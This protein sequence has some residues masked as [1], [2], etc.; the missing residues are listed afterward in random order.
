MKKV[1]LIINLL[2]IGFLCA[3][4]PSGALAT[5]KFTGGSF[6]NEANPGVGDLVPQGSGWL[7]RNDRDGNMNSALRNRQEEF[8]GLV[9]NQAT[10]T[11]SFSFWYLF[12]NPIVGNNEEGILQMFDPQ[13]EGVRVTKRA[14]NEFAVRV[15]TT[16]ADQTIVFT[17]PALSQPAWAHV[18][19]N[20]ARRTSNFAV[21]VLVNGNIAQAQGSNVVNSTGS[22]L[23]AGAPFILSPIVS[24]FGLRSATD[25]I[26][27]YN[28]ELALGDAINLSNEP[29]LARQSRVYV[30]VD[31]TGNQFGTSWTD[32]VT[33]LQ[34]AIA[35]ADDNAEI[36][37]AD[38]TYTSTTTNRTIPVMTIDK[39]VSILGGFNGSET[40]V[41]QR[42]PEAN[43]TIITGD[44]NDNDSV[45]VADNATRS[46]NIN[47]LLDVQVNGV[48]VDGITLSGAMGAD[49]LSSLNGSGAILIRNDLTD[50]TISNCIIEGNVARFR[51]SVVLYE[52]INTGVSTFT[53][54]RCIVR[55]NLTAQGGIT[56]GARAGSI[57]D[58]TIT[59][60]VIASN[61]S[62]DL[63]GPSQPNYASAIQARVMELGGV[64]NFVMINCTIAGNEDLNTQSFRSIYFDQPEANNNNMSIEIYNNVFNG[65]TDA[66]GFTITPIGVNQNNNRTYLYDFDSNVTDVAFTAI[67]DADEVNT[68]FASD[69]SF[70]DAINGD[71]RPVSGSILIDSG[72]SSLSN[73]SMDLSG[74]N[75][76]VGNSI[77]IGAYEFGS[78]AGLDNSKLSKI[79]VYPNPAVDMIYVDCG[80]LA[81]AK[82][83]LFNLHG[84][85]VKRST[86][87]KIEVAGLKTGF[88]ILKVEIKGG[89]TTTKRIFIK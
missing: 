5:Y 50:F 62:N 41:N 10:N 43:L 29:G 33:N 8:N 26:R 2:S 42:D 53:M 84:Q 65:S 46:E 86:Q 71:F 38:G 79:S 40:N 45:L 56:L 81:F 82:A 52:P 85:V 19:V 76:I 23:S 35:I 87:N 7:L 70:V 72:N 11:I 13:G 22:L 66:G 1:L 12:E 59:N 3:Q 17:H 44:L 88:Y 75:R 14:G 24:Q 20:V 51:G 77:D 18:V 6:V 49:S 9:L 89:N 48:I 61:L 60:T 78:T 25:D 31:A 30:D 69:P 55:N 54:D 74:N 36:W 83:E 27:I 67:P 4:I 73:T 47:K 64:L 15:K 39:T 28:R 32:A 68:I 21:N 58:A 80:D 57:L 63:P 37:I 34:A 16:T